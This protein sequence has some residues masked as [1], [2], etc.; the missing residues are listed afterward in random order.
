VQLQPQQEQ[1]ICVGFHTNRKSEAKL[2]KQQQK[3]RQ[4][5]QSLLTPAAPPTDAGTSSGGDAMRASSS[6]A[7]AHVQPSSVANGPEGR[8]Q[9]QRPE[10]L[11]LGAETSTSGVAGHSVR[12]KAG[13]LL[14]VV[15]GSQQGLS[16]GDLTWLTKAGVDMGANPQQTK[17]L[18]AAGCLSVQAATNAEALLAQ[19]SK[20]VHA[21]KQ[22]L[23]A[24][25]M[26][27]SCPYL[28]DSRARH[29][30][31]CCS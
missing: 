17:E 15:S 25:T 28:L 20:L 27:V 19:L 4:Q 1:Q 9:Q 21:Q 8:Q 29:V 7:Q 2:L 12:D 16:P 5:L 10:G 26:M 18:A 30:V 22:Q 6:A 31:P 24:L 23:R 13:A 3:L 14:A 11:P